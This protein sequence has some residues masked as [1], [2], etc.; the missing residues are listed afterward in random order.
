M[1]E[2]STSAGSAPVEP[3]PPDGPIGGVP[4]AKPIHIKRLEQAVRLDSFLDFVDQCMDEPQLE[5]GTGEKDKDFEEI[6]LEFVPKIQVEAA[7]DQ[8]AVAEAKSEQDIVASDTVAKAERRADKRKFFNFGKVKKNRRWLKAILLSDSSDLEDDVEEDN[9]KSLSKDDL[10][11]ML[12]L[13]KFGRQC[14]NQFYIESELQQY[15]Y[16]SAGLLSNYD[17]FLEHQRTIL[18]PKKIKKTSSSSKL[19]EKLKREREREEL[20]E[21]QG[22]PQMMQESPSDYDG[23]VAVFQDANRKF[24]SIKDVDARRK[25]IWLAIAKRDIP[26]AHKHRASVHNNIL[27]NCRKLAQGCQKEL[28]RAAIQSQRLCKETPYR[29]RRLTREMMAFWKHYEKVEKE[30]RR[31]AEKEAQEQ[32]R[33]DDEFREAKRQQRKLN[34]LITQTELYAH[35]MSRKLTGQGDDERNRILNLLD[36]KA[37][38]RQRTVKE[39]VLVDIE[40]D[41]YD[42]ETMKQRA[43]LSVTSAYSSFESSRTEFDAELRLPKVE[44]Q[45]PAAFSLSTTS[46]ETQHP[47]PSLFRGTLKCYQLKGMN[48]L[49]NLYDC[50][51]NGILADEMGLG[52]TV[53]SIAFLAHLAESQGIWGPFLV[54]APAST[55]HNWTQECARFASKFRVLPY[56]GNPQDRKTLRKFWGQRPAVVHTEQAE[57]HILVTSYQ[58]VVQDIRYFQRIKWHY[59]ILDE[60]Q[61]IKSSSSVRWRLLLGFNCRNRL[62]LTGT[63]IQNSMAELWALLHFIM[64]TLFDS[65]EEFN[66]WFSKDIESHI[67][68]QSGFDEEQLSRL[69]MILKPFMLRRV[70][71]DVENELSDKI[72][73]LMYC[74]LSTRQRLLY[75]AIKNKISIEDLLRSHS[76]SQTQTPTTTT[77]N[78][79]NL[80]MQFRKVCNH[81]ELFEKRETRSPLHSQL[82]EVTLPR[83]LLDDN[84]ESDPMRNK[85]LYNTMSVFSAENVHHSLFPPS[86]ERPNSSCDS[87]FSFSRF[88]DVSPGQLQASTGGM[89]ARWLMVYLVMKAAYRVY[90]DSLWKDTTRNKTRLLLVQCLRATSLPSQSCSLVLQDLVFTSWTTTLAS[91][92][93]HVYHHMAETGWHKRVRTRTGQVGVGAS[94]HSSPPSSSSSSAGLLSPLRHKATHS[95]PT[96]PKSPGL[97][98]GGGVKSPSGQGREVSTYKPGNSLLSPRMRPVTVRRCQPTEMPAFLFRTKPK[99][100]VGPV[101]LYCTDHQVFRKLLEL[102]KGDS[103]E[104]MQCVEYGSPEIYQDRRANLLKPPAVGGLGAIKPFH[105]WSKIQIPDKDYL[106]TDSGKMHVLDE[107]LSRLKDQ[108]HRILIYSQ[109]TRMIDILEEFL[110]HRKHTYMRLDGSSKISDRRDMVAG[111]QT[112]SDI[113]VFLL[114]TRA[115]GLGINLTAADTVIFYDSDWNPTVDQQAMDRAHRLGQTKQVTVYRLI[116]KGTIEEHILERAKEKSEIQRMVITGGNF[117]LDQLKPKEV[118]S[119][120]LDDE[121]IERKFRMNQYEKKGSDDRP[122]SKERKRKRDKDAE[123]PKDVGK[124]V[125][126]EVPD[127]ANVSLDGED[128]ILSLDSAAPSPGSVVSVGSESNPARSL[129]MTP[130]PM[131]ET[132]NDGLIIVDQVSPG[133]AI[134]GDDSSPVGKARGVGRGVRTKQVAG[135]VKK[136]S[137]RIGRPRK[138]IAAAA[139]AGARAGAVA[140]TAAAYAAYGFNLVGKQEPSVG[141]NT[142]VPSTPPQNTNP[143]E[144]LKSP[145]SLQVSP[146]AKAGSAGS[147]SNKAASME[148]PRPAGDGQASSL[149]L[150]KGVAPYVQVEPELGETKLE[151]KQS[152]HMEASVSLKSRSDVSTGSPSATSRSPVTAEFQISP[153]RA[154]VSLNSVLRKSPEQT[155]ESTIIKGHT[156]NKSI[157]S[158]VT[159]PKAIDQDKSSVLI[160]IARSDAPA[161]QKEQPISTAQ[162]LTQQQL[163]SFVQKE[164]LPQVTSKPKQ[165]ISLV[166]TVQQK[167][168]ETHKTSAT[169]YKGPVTLSRQPSPSD[170]KALLSSSPVFLKQTRPQSRTPPA[171]ELMRPSAAKSPIQT[172]PRRAKSPISSSQR[173]AISPI[174]KSPSH[175]SPGRQSPGQIA[176][177]DLTAKPSVTKPST[178]PTDGTVTRMHNSI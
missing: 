34:F 161:A 35:F 58:L 105:G 70:K 39:G 10:R 169:E 68:K 24:T 148:S 110:W 97:N 47:Q 18:G 115:G 78:L 21:E 15:Q 119:L 61:A 20:E 166:T 118:V 142:P 163:S 158:L 106:V 87:A 165:A 89:L 9:D 65:H 30:H 29:A 109:M 172:S 173:N 143:A 28:R 114:S 14:K 60:A 17:K 107:L 54:V 94:P 159:S 45:D 128:S 36:E 108:G 67:E 125:K 124:K 42:S 116:C 120:L 131:D 75:Q 59:M 79:M 5:E 147:P 22:E 98:F 84:I 41:D 82:D 95:S 25:R 31:K 77:N 137:M 96:T 175:R 151:V 49:I 134:E 141:P 44:K 91:H 135:V 3:I 111:F 150:T 149:D 4:L 63:P 92:A 52:K 152:Q 8:Q 90:H 126:N 102:R 11:E 13:H 83:L 86:S 57:F 26:K 53:Q 27:T 153:S 85:V 55:L 1:S 76:S 121:D 103:E 48:W 146:E 38:Q 140:G 40:A 155:K 136:A 71:K 154:G 157:L 66:D 171:V 132:S 46:M 176:P 123:T 88:V 138:G 62:L 7:T 74:Q 72:E 139:M 160:S 164:Y 112:R 69:H 23:S 37:P 33:I 167:Q 113:F 32:R 168:Q 19:R 162:T 12:R 64:P 144:A 81:P 16:Y 50:G 177:L 99:V 156:L 80:V 129:S 73:I 178:P 43:L 130:L 174:T 100:L 117:K 170:A 2:E 122:H 51:I 93:T 56:W 104:A 101:K 133:Q 6:G 145:V 127:S